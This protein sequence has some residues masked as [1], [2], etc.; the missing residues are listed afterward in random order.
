MTRLRT[1]VYSLNRR[2]KER[3]LPRNFGWITRRCL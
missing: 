2:D 1:S 3:E